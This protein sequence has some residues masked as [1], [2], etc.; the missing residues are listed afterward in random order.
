VAAITDLVYRCLPDD[1]MTNHLGE[2][3]LGDRQFDDRRFGDRKRR[4]VDKLKD[5]WAT[6]ELFVEIKYL[7]AFLVS[8]K[9]LV[10]TPSNHSNVSY[11]MHGFTKNAVL[12]EAN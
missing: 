3:P 10:Q 8:V 5:H 11:V 9:E 2:R 6:C 7:H 12:R 1:S 4:F